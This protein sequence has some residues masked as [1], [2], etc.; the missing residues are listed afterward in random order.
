V[1]SATEPVATSVP[2]AM[3]IHQKELGGVEEGRLTSLWLTMAVFLFM[4]YG[5]YTWGVY[6]IKK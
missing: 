5:C 2:L 3:K 4:L 1:P 6:P